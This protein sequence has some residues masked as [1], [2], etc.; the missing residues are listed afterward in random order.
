MNEN[1]FAYTQNK[2]SI[3]N[4]A[5]LP[6]AP[7]ASK[8]VILFPNSTICACI[9]GILVSNSFS[10]SLSLTVFLGVP[11][12]DRVANL[13]AAFFSAFS[14]FSFFKLSVSVHSFFNYY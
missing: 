12:A 10:S 2:P 6:L 5:R 1:A 11:I 7:F 4:A 3:T 9:C 14:A 13:D 8:S